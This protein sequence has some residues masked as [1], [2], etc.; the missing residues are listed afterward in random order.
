M[1]R[2]PDPRTHG[3]CEPGILSRE[4]YP[5]C[6][7]G[8]SDETAAYLITPVILLVP[9]LAW[10]VAAAKRLRDFSPTAFWRSRPSRNSSLPG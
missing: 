3:R 10:V 5:R 2:C 7:G 4:L 8:R 9:A 6:H 1:R